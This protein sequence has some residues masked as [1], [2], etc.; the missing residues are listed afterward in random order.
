MF[1]KTTASI[2][3][4]VLFTAI[5]PFHTAHA[6]FGGGLPSNIAKE[7]TQILNNA[8]LNIDTAMNT[9]SASANKLTAVFTGGLQLKEFAL[10]PLAWMLAKGFIEQMTD[11]LVRWI[12]SGFQ[13]QP[14]FVNRLDEYL[15]SELDS[16]AGQ[17]LESLPLGDYLCN[18]FEPM[19]SFAITK[20]YQQTTRA[21]PQASCTLSDAQGNLDAFLNG[22]WIE[23]GGTD[24]LREMALNPQN[25]P[26]GAYLEAQ[27]AFNDL[28]AGEAAKETQTLS[29]GEGFLSQKV[30]KEDSAI[31][32]DD[33]NIQTGTDCRIVTPGQSIEEALTFQLSTGQ[34]SL[35]TADEIDEIFGALLS[36][37][38]NQA[39]KGA[40][41]LLGL[42]RQGSDA[43]SSSGSSLRGIEGEE[44]TIEEAFGGNNLDAILDGAQT[45]WEAEALNNTAEQ[46]GA[47]QDDR[48]NETQTFLDD[49][50]ESETD[51]A[52]ALTDGAKESSEEDTEESALLNVLCKSSEG[53]EANECPSGTELV[54]TVKIIDDPTGNVGAGD[55]ANV[56]V[57]WWAICQ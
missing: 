1:K 13:G 49:L 31:A 41:G 17:F 34:R 16:V 57:Q 23:G 55:E 38:L 4:L 54:D 26:F 46:Q 47:L 45:E 8:R 52:Q 15:L 21:Q 19:V 35:I 22:G 56:T 6:L 30:C 40:S 53:C 5:T 9:I 24:T 50:T 3:L 36:Q 28:L 20:N 37:L 18:G 12:N 51:N 39:L 14:M 11:E 7:S 42:G 43:Y 32:G 44:Q 2:V 27:V 48:T 10:D 25:T 33:G 29:F